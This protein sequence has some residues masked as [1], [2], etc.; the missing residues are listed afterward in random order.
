MKVS[1]QLLIHIMDSA[2]FDKE[3]VSKG[4]FE[5][6]QL[7]AIIHPM[8]IL[9]WLSQNEL[10]DE[11]RNLFIFILITHIH[12]LTFQFFPA[13]FALHQHGDNNKFKT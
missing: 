3:H 4:A 6:N 12:H 1:K 8:N 9:G 5:L 10:Y 2:S 7:S 11:F 13:F